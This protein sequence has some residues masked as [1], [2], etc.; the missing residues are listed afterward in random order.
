MTFNYKKRVQEYV[1][2]VKRQTGGDF[3]YRPK[4][5]DETTKKLQEPPSEGNC[6][7][8][9]Q[10]L[11]YLANWYSRHGVVLISQ[12]DLKGWSELSLAA[13]YSFWN[14]RIF[15]RSYDRHPNKRM[16]ENFAPLLSVWRETRMSAST[17]GLG[18]L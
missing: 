8:L 9:A 17:L 12:G 14:I 7:G 18:R 1:D 4:D 6:R 15:C 16:A 13:Q 5:F 3:N 11:A 10:Q 2:W